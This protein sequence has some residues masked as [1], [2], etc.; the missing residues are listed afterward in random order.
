[1]QKG[2][3]HQLRVIR[4]RMQAYSKGEYGERDGATFPYSVKWATEATE[5]VGSLA[6]QEPYN[7]LMT[8]CARVSPTH[9]W[10]SRVKYF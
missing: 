2:L 7:L 5:H 3:D 1:M 6:A 4:P 8:S 9:G 10:C